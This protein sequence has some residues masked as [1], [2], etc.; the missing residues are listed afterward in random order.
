MG[1]SGAKNPLCCRAAELPSGALSLQG[2]FALA[3]LHCIALH[4]I[5]IKH[6]NLL[7]KNELLA[8]T[9]CALEALLAK[10]PGVVAGAL[11]TSA[12]SSHPAATPIWLH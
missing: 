3:G 1:A 5:C 12:A 7:L 9:A 2:I 8:L 6:S 11:P 10:N 4:C